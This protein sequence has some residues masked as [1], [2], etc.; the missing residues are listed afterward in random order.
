[1][2]AGIPTIAEIQRTVAAECET[3]VAWMTEPTGTP[4]TRLWLVSHPR[5]EAIALAA[6]LTEHSYVRIGH[7]FGRRDHSTVMSACQSVAKR[8]R[9][10]PKVDERLKRLTWELLRGQR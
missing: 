3:P 4:R 7:F 5:Q 2:A 9:A 6:L 8:R 10:D 1:M